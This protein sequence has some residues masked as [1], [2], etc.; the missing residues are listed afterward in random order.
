M[1][2]E[3]FKISLS[4]LGGTFDITSC[5]VLADGKLME[6]DTA[7]GGNAGGHKVNEE[8]WILLAEIFGS[9]QIKIFRKEKREDE[10]QLERVFE[11]MKKRFFWN[12]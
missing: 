8:F 5:Q 4:F 7:N 10:F 12:N 3:K 2:T 1:T 11:T 6:I 9:N